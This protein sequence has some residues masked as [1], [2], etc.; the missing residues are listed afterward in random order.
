MFSIILI[1]FLD[2]ILSLFFLVILFPLIILISILILIIDGMPIFYLSKRVG[3][4]GLLFIFFKFRTMKVKTH[5]NQSD[6][7]TFLGKYLRRTSLD[8]LPQL[9]NVL[10][11]DMSIVGPRPLPLNIEK[12]IPKDK[13]II[14]RSIK[15][16]ITGY[17][18]VLYNRKKRN[19]EEKIKDDISLINNFSVIDYLI[20]ILRTIPVLIKRFKFNLKGDTL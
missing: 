11:N 19:W 16:G 15:P 20:I 1:R 4:K 8:E 3:K 6:E 13:L 17:S 10:K 9:Y 7:I 12:Q 2:I 18:Q 14:R 5:T